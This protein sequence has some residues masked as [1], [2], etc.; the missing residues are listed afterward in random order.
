[1]ATKQDLYDT[2]HS[3]DAARD[4]NAPVLGGKHKPTGLKEEALKDW[5]KRLIVNTERPSDGG[6]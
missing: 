2:H 3:K 1:M 4:H 5:N 6:R